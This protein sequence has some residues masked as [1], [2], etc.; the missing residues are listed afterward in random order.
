[1]NTLTQEQTEAYNKAM[2]IITD[3]DLWIQ[4]EILTGLLHHI[5]NNLGNTREQI[6]EAVKQTINELE[7]IEYSLVL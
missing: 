1:M 6:L 3:T 4:Y 2:E 7:E 5:Y